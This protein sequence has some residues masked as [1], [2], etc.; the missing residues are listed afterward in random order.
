MLRIRFVSCRTLF[1]TIVTILNWVFIRVLYQSKY[2]SLPH[3]VEDLFGLARTEVRGKRF[4]LCLSLL[5]K[6]RLC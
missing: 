4:S 6:N 3:S 5:C 1:F 2:R